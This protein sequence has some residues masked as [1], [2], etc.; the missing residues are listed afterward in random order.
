LIRKFGKFIL[1]YFLIFL[2]AFLVFRIFDFLGIVLYFATFL[3]LA[4]VRYPRLRYL[5][6][7]RE[8]KDREGWI[9]C[10]GDKGQIIPVVKI[11]RSSD[12]KSRLSSHNTAA[13]F[14]MWVYFNFP[15]NDAV[16]VERLLH[17]RYKFA[18]LRLEWFFILT[19]L[20]LFE[21]ILLR[22]FG[23]GKTRS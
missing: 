12:E 10:F 16:Y 15:V 18:H 20:M 2:F 1:S 19:P 23:A 22:L 9:Y 21:I 7:R 8:I 14:G 11:G 5:M 13:P 4:L 6:Q 3:F 17:Q